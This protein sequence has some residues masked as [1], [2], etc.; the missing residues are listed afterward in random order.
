MVLYVPFRGHN[1]GSS[2]GYKRSFVRVSTIRTQSIPRAFIVARSTTA[3]STRKNRR[4]LLCTSS[5]TSAVC[6]LLYDTKHECIR[7]VE[8]TNPKLFNCNAHKTARRMKL[9]LAVSTN[10]SRLRKISA[11]PWERESDKPERASASM[12]NGAGIRIRDPEIALSR[13]SKRMSGN[14]KSGM[15]RSSFCSSTQHFF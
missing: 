1:L 9:E 10:L 6:R 7:I 2:L 15:Q 3:V 5:G 14:V 12:A 8:R 11:S 13:V 4:V